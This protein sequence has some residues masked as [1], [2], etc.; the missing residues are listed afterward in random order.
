MTGIYVRSALAIAALS[1]AAASF[2][3]GL[4][5]TDTTNVQYLDST[6]SGQFGYPGGPYGWDATG[7]SSAQD[8]STTNL[9]TYCSSLHT[10]FSAGENPQAYIVVDLSTAAGLA[11]VAADMPL[12]DIGAGETYDSFLQAAETLQ[13]GAVAHFAVGH[14]GSAYAG[15]TGFGLTEWLSNPLQ[16]AVWAHLYDGAVGPAP[17]AGSYSDVY[18]L[19]PYGGA[20]GVYNSQHYYHGQG[21]FVYS[22]SPTPEPIT[23][24]LGLAGIALA[25]RR[26]VQNSRKA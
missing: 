11:K 18:W 17:S 19:D 13:A 8:F 7:T 12:I 16:N 25:V 9:W 24:G 3:S 1:V 4:D 2:A 15:T 26:K 20:A 14:P 6:N 21:Q 22:P 5:L 10:D 23:I